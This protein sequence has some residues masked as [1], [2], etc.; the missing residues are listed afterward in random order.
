[1]F[2]KPYKYRVYSRKEKEFLYVLQTRAW[3]L[4]SLYTF[5]RL[6]SWMMGT[7]LWLSDE[8]QNGEIEC[9]EYNRELIDKVTPTVRVYIMASIIFSALLDILC[10]KYRN[11]ANFIIYLESFNEVA[12]NIVPTKEYLEMKS[13]IMTLLLLIIFFSFYCDKGA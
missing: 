4:H 3:L 13:W 7:S 5:Q 1:M 8:C 12:Y 11:L 2:L 10:Y 9:P 6:G